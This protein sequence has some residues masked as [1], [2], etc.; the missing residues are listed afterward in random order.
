M[1]VRKT[2]IRSEHPYALLTLKGRAL[3]LRTLYGGMRV[4]CVCVSSLFCV[5]FRFH[6]LRFFTKEDDAPV[7][8]VNH[9]TPPFKYPYLLRA[10]SFLLT[11]LFAVAVCT[12]PISAVLW[13]LLLLEFLYTV[14]DI[15]LKCSLLALRLYVYS[16]ILLCLLKSSRCVWGWEGSR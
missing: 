11:L 10:G 5:C 4:V 15:W 9:I 3:E 12:L 13:I 7:H 16:C 1:C 14:F 6:S 2:P 8:A